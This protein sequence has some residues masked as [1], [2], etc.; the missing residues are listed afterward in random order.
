MIRAIVVALAIA[1]L[2]AGTAATRAVW[3]GRSA[4]AAGDEARE[5]GEL[6]AAIERY[7]RAA[8]WYLP[9][10]PHVRR[11]Y[12]RLEAIAR[13]AEDAGD[14]RLALTAWRGVRGS[15]L[16][17]RGLYVPF[18]ERL[19]PAQENIAQLMAAQGSGAGPAAEGAAQHL[20]GFERTDAPSVAGAITALGGLAL[21]LAGLLVFALRGVTDD[22]ELAP[23]PAAAAGT[24]FALG[25]MLWLGGLAAA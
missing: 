22:D 25:L 9:W 14:L 19:A 13:A 4:L 6:D 16:A 2:G 12:D 8:R 24:L 5:R 23:R 10:A 17:T 1:A 3:E 7:R 15:I 18:E 21:W 11:A 20:E